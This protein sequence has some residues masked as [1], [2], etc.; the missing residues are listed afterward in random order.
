MNLWRKL[1]TYEWCF[2][3]IIL[4]WIKVVG[5]ISINEIVEG[6]SHI[7]RNHD[8]VKDFSAYEWFMI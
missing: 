3:K 5:K 6:F 7:I 4:L 1:L 2:M 8:V